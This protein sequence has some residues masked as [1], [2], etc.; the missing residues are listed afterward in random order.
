[1][2][3][4]TDKRARLKEILDFARLRKLFGHFSVVTGLDVALF[5][6][7]GA[8]LLS[9]RKPGT[10]CTTAKN[11]RKC[12]EMIAYGGVMSSKL[13]EP[14]IFAC[15]C[16]L[17]MCSS[18]VMFGDQLIGSIACGPAILWEPDDIALSEIA[19]KTRSMGIRARAGDFLRHT[20]SCGC[21]NVTSAA[22][23]LFIIV[24]S[25][26]REHNVYLKQR[27]RIT[28]QQRQISELVQDRKFAAAGLIEMEKRASALT[29]PYETEK[30]LIAF[31]Q[32]G[33]K[34]Q[35][36]N[37][38]NT[39]LSVIFCFA[40]GNI[41][42]IR[43]RIFELVAFLSRAAVEA[44]A[45]LRE[46][47]SITKESFEICE[48]GTDFERLC[49]LTTQAMERFIDTVHQNRG[50]KRT[51]EH[52]SKAIG[53]ITQNYADDLSL[54]GV[55]S[56]VFVSEYYLSHLFRKEMNMT[57]SNYV[58]RIRIDKAKEYLK[59]DRQAQ[60]QEVAGKVGFNDANY[61]AKIFKKTTGVTPKEY[62]SFFCA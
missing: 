17:I 33:N 52:L 9:G 32:S 29:Y 62:H 36:T 38:L 19:E 24:N 4:G 56:R 49:F 50:Q 7:S 60:I 44:G 1:M 22:Q 34:Q 59:N 41:D 45:P 28:E 6:D 39:L 5:D 8:E 11:C 58:C 51:S 21:V 53:Y 40:S 31:V 54:S 35:A 55:A 37:I 61:F 15:G 23:I 43:V 2:A 57:F 14:Y 42:T 47:N 27:A 18:P 46:I 20:P 16:G 25:L 3:K 26:T 10:I 13:G 12:R 48:D 30:E